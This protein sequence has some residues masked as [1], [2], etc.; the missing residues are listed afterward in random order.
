MESPYRINLGLFIVF[1]LCFICVLLT[2]IN[3]ALF[4]DINTLANHSYSFIWSNL[5][6]LG[7]ALPACAIMLLF[8]R[9]RPDLVWSG[10]LSTLIATLLVNL[11]K[12]YFNSPRPPSVIESNLINIIGPAIYSHSF[13]S[14]HTVTIF[15]LTGIVMFYFRTMFL[16]IIMVILAL[17]IGLSRIVVGV[18][19]P[20]DVLAGAAI[21]I[22]CAVTG[23]YFINKLGWKS[24]KTVQLITG[25]LLILSNLYLLF[26]YDCRYEKAVYLQS[27]F[28]LTV[29]ILGMR[30]FILLWKNAE[31]IHA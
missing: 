23:V 30:E 8:I 24:N 3:K 13:P 5:T 9:K 26:I 12:F 7:D 25:F 2:G 6:F 21:G 27:F 4:L 10:I 1:L 28:A 29:L 14:G 18:H 16:R 19:W 22:L 31:D 11:L 15:T 17:F 20:A